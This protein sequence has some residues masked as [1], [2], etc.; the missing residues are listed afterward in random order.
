[1]GKKDSKHKKKS[2][3]KK[4]KKE[5]KRH[6]EKKSKHYS[7]DSSDSSSDSSSYKSDKERKPEQKAS[8]ERLS[9]AQDESEWN[10][11]FSDRHATVKQRNVEKKD[12]DI[13][14]KPGQ[15]ARELNPYWK[16]GGNGLP[17]TR[18]ESLSQGGKNNDVKYLKNLLKK[19]TEIAESTG[20][21][22]AKIVY[23]EWGP[24][25]KLKQIIEESE[26][27]QDD[28]P[29]RGM[30]QRPSSPSDLGHKSADERRMGFMKPGDISKYDF[31]NTYKRNWRKKDGAPVEEG[32]ETES[33]KSKETTEE[34]SESNRIL[35]PDELNA[36]AA[37]AMKA[38]I[39]GNKELCEKLRKEIEV[40]K[41]N[42]EAASAGGSSKGEGKR[43]EVVVL[44]KTNSKG[45]S[46][47][48]DSSEFSAAEGGRKRRRGETHKGNER[49]RYFLDDDKYNIKTMFEK[50]K[51]ST[52]GQ[53]DEMFLKMAKKG[54]NA[55][56]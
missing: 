30:F 27:P 15:S 35:T 46:R 47:P 13:L 36:L 40:A 11:L 44:T 37:K 1:M 7:S 45:F 21:S 39:M 43:E 19:A 32:V 41:K 24:L 42:R 14:D 10:D 50:E 33:S 55:F 54:E 56:D 16:D 53:S 38:E 23:E 2:H 28:N 20:E 26:K 3:K 4:H 25:D 48:C 52:P 51:F 8:V 49:V 34:K 31:T 22:V 18:E 29:R 17:P 5:K 6:K 9:H 12:R